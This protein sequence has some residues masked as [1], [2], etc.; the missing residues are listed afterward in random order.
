MPHLLGYECLSL[1]YQ[2]KW[3]LSLI[4][5]RRCLTR[6]QLIFRHLFSCKYVERELTIAWKDN[7]NTQRAPTKTTL[8]Y[9]LIIQ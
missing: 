5:S 9:N 4:L 1:D 6:Y 7:K 8:R 2:V 3:P